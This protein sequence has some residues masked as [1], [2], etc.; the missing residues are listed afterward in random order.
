M[1][2]RTTRRSSSRSTL[3]DVYSVAFTVTFVFGVLS[4]QWA[5]FLLTLAS[6]FV[7]SL[8]GYAAQPSCEDDQCL[9]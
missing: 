3:A 2:P 1:P 4:G 7:L 5:L 8:A 9:S 6:P